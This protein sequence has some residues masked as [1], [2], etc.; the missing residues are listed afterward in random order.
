[1]FATN[2]PSSDN[3]ATKNRK[4]IAA[5]MSNQEISVV[6]LLTEAMMKP[7]NLLAAF[8]DYESHYKQ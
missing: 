1:M 4:N 6:Q 5:R 7:K 2:D 3:P 8:N